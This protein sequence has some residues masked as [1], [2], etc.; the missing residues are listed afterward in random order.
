M[1]GDWSKI[2]MQSDGKLDVVY[3]SGEPDVCWMTVSWM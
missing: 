1:S 3:S 2:I